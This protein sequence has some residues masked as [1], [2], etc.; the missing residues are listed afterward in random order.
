MSYYISARHR[1]NWKSMFNKTSLLNCPKVAIS[2][3]RYYRW[4]MN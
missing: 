3:I 2:H 1:L 4:V